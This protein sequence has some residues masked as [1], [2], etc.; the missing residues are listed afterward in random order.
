ART[1]REVLDVA[2]DFGRPPGLHRLDDVLLEYQLSR[3]GEALGRL[4]SLL[5][6]LGDDAELLRTLGTYL[7]CGRGG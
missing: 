7:R 6:P 5:Q 3:P 4:A 2:L 1:A